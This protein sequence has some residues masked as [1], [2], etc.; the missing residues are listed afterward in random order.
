MNDEN[1]STQPSTTNEPRAG[2]LIRG[3]ADPE[4]LDPQTV[5]QLAAWFGTPAVGDDLPMTEAQQ[6]EAE[7]LDNRQK[8]REKIEDAADPAFL[9]KFEAKRSQGD[10]FIKLPEALTLPIETALSKFDLDTWGL[11]TVELREVER[12]DEIIDGLR[13]TVPQALLRD[14]HRPVF[15]WQP[16]FLPVDVGVD[17]GGA[18]ATRATHELVVTPYQVR[19]DEQPIASKDGAALLEDLQHRLDEPWDEIE[20][21]KERLERGSETPGPED[22]KWFGNVGYDPTI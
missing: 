16:L 22:F 7:Y 12:P 11:P 20:I 8:N 13:E 5:A 4:Q 6:A 21:P 19:M 9:A 10:S 1:N 15:G 18:D 14:L 3:E 2:E 17:I